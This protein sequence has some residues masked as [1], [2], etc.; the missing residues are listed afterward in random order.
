MIF[1]TFKQIINIFAYMVILIAGLQ[2]NPILLILK[3]ENV[4]HWFI[5]TRNVYMLEELG[6]PLRRTNEDKVINQYARK[7]LNFCKYNDVFILNGRK[8]RDTTLSE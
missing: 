6:I 2:N 1:K 8:T 7:L 5:D 4:E 3:D